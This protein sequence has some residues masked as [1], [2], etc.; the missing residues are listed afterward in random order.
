MRTKSYILILITLICF[1][2]SEDKAHSPVINSEVFDTKIPADMG[3]INFGGVVLPKGT[4]SELSEDGSSLKVY[5]P[6]GIVYIAQDLNGDTG[7]ADEGGY[8]CTS[9]CS[10][11]CDVVKLGDEVGCSRC[12]EESTEKCVGKSSDDDEGIF[13]ALGAGIGGGFIDLNSG[14]S[15]VLK[16]DK[17]PSLRAPEWEVLIKHPKVSE[18]LD[19]FINE[20]WGD[21]DINIETSEVVVVSIFGTYISLKVPE[22]FTSARTENEIIG[23]DEVSCDC[24]SG[25]GGCT[26]EAIKK[27]GATIGHKCIAGGCESCTMTWED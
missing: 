7:D 18:E 6:E 4:R 13:P 5:L 1:A 11:G 10:G 21:T 27:F 14:I 8:T 25:V 24:T 3:G 19:S 2:C 22:G 12:P 26:Y 15:F 20:I 23:G 17:K 9:T 16:N